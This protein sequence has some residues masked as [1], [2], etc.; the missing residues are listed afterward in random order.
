L[1]LESQSEDIITNLCSVTTLPPLPFLSHVCSY[2]FLTQDTFDVVYHLFPIPF[3]SLRGV[4]RVITHF[5]C[6][7][8]IFTA[9]VQ[10]I[11]SGMSGITSHLA[12]QAH[13]VAQNTQSITLAIC[14]LPVPFIDLICSRIGNEPLSTFNPNIEHSLAWHPFLINEDVHGP[15]LDFAICKMANTTSSMLTLVQASDLS[16]WHEISDKLEDF[17][18]HAWACEVASGV[19]LALVFF[20]FFWCQRLLF[21][22][23]TFWHW[24]TTAMAIYTNR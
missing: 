23:L 20:F 10:F 19:H 17:L 8:L 9:L 2:L 13:T 24:M 21:Y 7:V 15:A 22:V 1:P 6:R 4:N 3:A 5:L 14:A 12:S 18:Q 16:R 11:L